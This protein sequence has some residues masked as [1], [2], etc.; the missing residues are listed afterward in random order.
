MKEF[1]LQNARY[2]WIGG[3]M[4]VANII[5]G[6][7]GGTIAV[8]FGVYE[9][10]MEALGN[11]M[12]DREKRWH[13][14]RF[15]AVLFSGAFIAIL[16]LS[17]LLHWAFQNHPL[18]TVY[19]FIGLI[20][21]SIPVVL[22]SHDD[23]KFNIK[24]GTSFLT[25]LGIVVVLAL[26]QNESSSQGAVFN[27]D[28]Y[29]LM[30]Y[31]YYLICGIIAASAMIIPGVSGSF[32]L[33]LLGIYW[34]VLGS[35]SGL[36]TILLADGFTV[37][38]RVRIS[39][40]GSLGIGVVIGILVISKVMAWALKQYPA[41]TMYAILGLIVGSLYQIYPGLTFNISGLMAITTLII[42]FIIS[43]RFGKE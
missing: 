33:I 9:K 2:F 21:G 28:H 11:F 3:A 7:S 1:I 30:D 4:G 8:V 34:D 38:M 18:P 32:I 37:E 16:S 24:R 26:V 42:G 13:Y 25:G 35:L 31:F 43:L 5:P 19:F 15:L 27:A 23:M 12:T 17:P 39:L 22:R 14:I 40:L 6:V 20:I 10:L 29:V 41:I 36:S